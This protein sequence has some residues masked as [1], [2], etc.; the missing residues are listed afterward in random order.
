[1]SPSHFCLNTLFSNGQCSPQEV[2]AVIAGFIALVVLLSNLVVAAFTLRVNLKSNTN[3]LSHQ[4][5]LARLREAHELDM[6]D[7]DHRHELELR[8]SDEKAKEADRLHSVALAKRSSDAAIAL[9]E[10]RRMLDLQEKYLRETIDLQ[11]KRLRD[12]RRACNQTLKEVEELARLSPTLERSD[13]LVRTGQILRKASVILAPADDKIPDLPEPCYE[14][15]G[16]VRDGLVKVILSWSTEKADRQP[17][18]RMHTQMIAAVAEMQTAVTV[19]IPAAQVEETRVMNSLVALP[20]TPQ[21]VAQEL[22]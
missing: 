17:T 20:Q 13:M 3:T 7:K 4:S 19:F 5:Q 2:G 9:E 22:P 1:M 12:L 14:P 6:K 11:V 10:R 16:T 18:S 8:A 21:S 15:L